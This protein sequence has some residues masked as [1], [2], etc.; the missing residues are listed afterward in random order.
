MYT[1]FWKNWMLKNFRFRNARESKISILNFGIIL[2]WL[3]WAAFYSLTASINIPTFHLDGAF[4]TASGLYRLDVG[5]FPGKD[6]YPYLG[7]GPLL[8]LYPFFKA[9]GANIS[10]SVFASHF[11][12]LMISMLSVAFIWQLIW[13]PK[14]F[15]TSIVA[16]SFLFFGSIGIAHYFSLSLPDWMMFGI[17]PGNSLRPIRA[18]APYLVAMVFYF[19][20]SP[21]DTARNRYISAG[22]LTGSILLWSNDFAIPS[23]GLLALF[24][25]VNAYFRAEFLLKNLFLYSIAAIFSSMVLFALATDGHQVEL[26]YYNFYD[27][28]WDQWWFFGPYGESTRIFSLRQ[29]I[30][31]FSW[32]NYIPLFALALTFYCVFRVRRIEY[33]LLLLIGVTLFF[34]GVLASVGGHLGGYFGGF[35]FWGV[36]VIL[37]GLSR[38]FW[39]ELIK[40]FDADYE[41][42]QVVLLIILGVSTLFMLNSFLHLRSESYSANSDPNR[43]FVPELGGYLTNDW[44]DYVVLARNSRESN[45]FEEYWGLWS[46]IRKTSPSWPVDAVIHALGGTREIAAKHLQGADII[47]ST[48]NVT[49]PVWQPW[50]LSQNYWFYEY[51]LKDWVP[52]ALSPTTI[53]WRKGGYSHLLESADCNSHKN[54][55]QSLVLQ[56]KEPGFYE[57]D[58]QYSFSGSGR[59]L[60]MVQ[61]NISFGASAG[62]Y[63]SINPK[64]TRVKF[65]IYIEKGG[66]VILD[67]EIIGG[68]DFDFYIKS[69]STK[70]MPLID[71]EVLRVPL[72]FRDDFFLTDG[73]WL[74]GVARH[75]AG[76]VVPN[77]KRFA[78]RYKVGRFIQ[79][80]GGEVREVTRTHPSG[81]Y[82]NIYLNG[83]PLN[84]EKVGLPNKF[85]VV[86]NTG[87]SSREIKK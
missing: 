15:A 38:F 10:A 32:E 41:I 47:I 18:A 27:V 65:P 16:G 3:G 42:R 46:A 8:A 64:S 86:D 33:G 4:Q 52:S 77:T 6:F 75:W 39:F 49:S 11:M 36:M 53:V 83:D 71:D 80:A 34:G 23:A 9:F 63:V 22:L 66:D 20:I 30:R 51:L 43:F 21:I 45:V 61:N 78:D 35:Y 82:L 87:Y 81:L 25:F 72:I 70:Y 1:I 12:V 31:L 37:I 73:N 55:S 50:N 79:F 5:Q 58:M 67:V 40:I 48:R 44:S 76:F 19:F 60:V 26:F 2:C 69:C 14:L 59:F 84:A 29:L 57:V 17:T 62:G 7:I 85:V 56:A 13:R 68:V 24:I 28:A 54:G 74:R